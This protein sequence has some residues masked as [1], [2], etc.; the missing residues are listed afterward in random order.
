MYCPKTHYFDMVAWLNCVHMG[1]WLIHVSVVDL[2]RLQSIT[3][4]RFY[5][6]ICSFNSSYCLWLAKYMLG[7]CSGSGILH[8]IECLVWWNIRQYFTY[9]L[10]LFELCVVF[11][12]CNEYCCSLSCSFSFLQASI[13]G[14]PRIKYHY[15]CEQ[16][17]TFKFYHA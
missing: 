16:T 5:N 7:H 4:S 17:A 8:L 3:I 9:R 15:R 10:V 12:E 1:Q 6:R 14:K 13:K 2:F 11:N